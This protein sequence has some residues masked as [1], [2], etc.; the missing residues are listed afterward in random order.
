MLLLSAFLAEAP[1]PCLLLTFLL[2]QC[3]VGGEPCPSEAP[4]LSMGSRALPTLPHNLLW[5]PVPWTEPL[6][7]FPSNVCRPLLFQ[8]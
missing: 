7:V 4:P 1:L 6:P 8:T 2:P 5:L 3:S